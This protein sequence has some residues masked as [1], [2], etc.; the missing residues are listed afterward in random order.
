MPTVVRI[1]NEA[2]AAS[3]RVRAQHQQR[4]TTPIPVGRQEHGSADIAIVLAPRGE[5]LRLA[6]AYVCLTRRVRGS[7]TGHHSLELTNYVPTQVLDFE[8]LVAATTV[9]NQ[10]ELKIAA[11]RP[12]SALGATAWASVRQALTKL[13]PTIE[14][15]IDRIEKDLD[16]IRFGSGMQQ[17][18]FQQVRDAVV[19]CL[20]ALRID[21]EVVA[22]WRFHADSPA[23][24]GLISRPDHASLQ[25]PAYAVQSQLPGPWPTTALRSACVQIRGQRGPTLTLAEA[26]PSESAD[27]VG[28]DLIYHRPRSGTLILLRYEP[29]KAPRTQ[30]LL[31][32]EGSTLE[33]L[34]AL[35][36]R[37]RA[38]GG[39]DAAGQQMSLMSR[40]SATSYRLDSSACWLKFWTPPEVT[41]PLSR[42]PLP[43]RIV[44]LGLYE[45]LA[46]ASGKDSAIPT[47]A[48]RRSP[49]RWLSNS[50]FTSLLGGDWIGPDNLPTSEVQH[51]ITTSLN[52]KRA[53]IY[54]EG[55]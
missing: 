3:L 55:N 17:L 52:M 1:A 24:T 48:K 21:R 10:E 6:V 41:K 7:L 49:H 50:L 11:Q 25:A 29:L 54:A 51:A 34:R 8:D 42:E 27:A 30:R 16:P 23:L 53:L 33:Q 12:G 44:P 22:T 39:G 32:D 5:Q 47:P 35:A 20:N 14:E 2:D 36:A 31:E 28:L 4:F 26:Q 19:L 46:A 37:L 45:N 18:L 43:G 38:G 40:P 9:P 13:D 15:H